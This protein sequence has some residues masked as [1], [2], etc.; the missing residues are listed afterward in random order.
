MSAPIYQTQM[1]ALRSEYGAF[2]RRSEDFG[3]VSLVAL[4]QTAGDFSDAGGGDLQ[5][6]RTNSRV[7]CHIDFS[8]GMFV[9]WWPPGA[10][11][12]SPP[13]FD[14]SILVDQSC[15]TEG[16]IVSMAYLR[17]LDTEARLPAD[18][19]FGAA[20]ARFH[21]DA[22]LS[23]VIDRLWT[24]NR[25]TDS[26]AI[27]G[28]LV[29]I[30]ARLVDWKNATARTVTSP[31][32]RLS[33]FHL[34]LA[35]DRLASRGADRVGLVD[36]A[37]LCGYSPFHFSRAF[38]ASTGLSPSQFLTMCRVEHAKELLSD[39]DESVADVAATAG[40]GDPSY[41][42]RVFAREAGWSPAA[43]RREYRQIAPRPV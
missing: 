28:A 4:S 34:R 21:E 5:I 2:I 7:Q 18:A 41:F 10:I 25:A 38:K 26:L 40:F 30:S 15:S 9:S 17:S 33:P 23:A 14:N 11:G 32:E 8:A 6:Q 16:V 22:A 29:W 20:H 43:W 27:D 13:H 24:F 42:A 31:K 3:P 37:A 36:L 12:I 35:R 1:E 39:T 19:D